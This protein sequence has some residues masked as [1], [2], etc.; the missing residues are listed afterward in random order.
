M[1]YILDA[2]KKSENE[3]QSQALP[4]IN[5]VHERPHLQSV[6]KQKI[7]P[8]IL[9][10]VLI[11]NVSGIW[12]VWQRT[13]PLNETSANTPEN[14]A[15]LAD[16]VFKETTETE[17][18]AQQ[19]LPDTIVTPLGVQE[20]VQ[21]IL[22]TPQDL[23]KKSPSTSIAQSLGQES[24]QD[25]VNKPLA[26]DQP[27]KR[28][29]ALPTNIQRQI[30]DL[31]FSSHLYADDDSFRMVNINGSIFHEGDYI[32]EGIRLER[33]SEEGVVL[34]YLHYTFEISVIRDWSFQ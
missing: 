7:W 5:A 9:I 15:I 30:P 4:D 13:P 31:R 33:I 17:H 2:L 3:R 25:L 23:F 34:N 20:V 22:I 19:K 29:T 10:V 27:V 18:V 26:S 12:F 24:P 21:E 16:S 32:A 11:L 1:S 6:N 14:S 8:I 28:I